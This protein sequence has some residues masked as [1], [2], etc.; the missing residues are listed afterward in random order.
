M[1]SNLRF[2]VLVIVGVILVCLYGIIG[3][4]TSVGAISENWKKSIRLGTDL[5][6]GSQLVLEVQVQDAFM[7]EADAVIERIKEAT[8]KAGIEVNELSRTEPK[9]LKEADS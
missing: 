7:A 1:K 2:R 8:A 4:P 3:I 5:K 9:S 6:G